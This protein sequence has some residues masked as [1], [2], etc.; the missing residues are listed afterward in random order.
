MIH[1]LQN[2][3]LVVIKFLN[4]SIIK[5]CIL[6]SYWRLTMHTAATEGGHA[7]IQPKLVILPNFLG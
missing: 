2:K 6:M 5:N 3:V 4:I 1:L 7:S